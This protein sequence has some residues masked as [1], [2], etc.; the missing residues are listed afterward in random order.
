MFDD[1]FVRMWRMYLT[2]SIVAFQAGSL[3]LFQV[4]FARE[5]N[6]DISWTRKHLYP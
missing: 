2:A 1:Q 5:L 4:L 3:Q 6:N